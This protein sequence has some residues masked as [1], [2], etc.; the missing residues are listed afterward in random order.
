MVDIIHG[1]VC[2]QMTANSAGTTFGVRITFQTSILFMS[3]CDAAYAEK[4]DEHLLESRSITQYVHMRVH[5]NVHVHVHVYV[6]IHVNMYIC[7]ST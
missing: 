1:A 5:V 7:I 2:M 6:H 4:R 3:E